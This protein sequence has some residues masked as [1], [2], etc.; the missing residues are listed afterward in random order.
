M[1]PN[2]AGV[3]ILCYKSRSFPIHTYLFAILLNPKQKFFGIQSEKAA[4]A[5]TV[6]VA[7]CKKRE[8][9]TTAQS[10]TK[11]NIHTQKRQRNSSNRNILF[12]IE[13]KRAQT[14]QHF[15]LSEMQ[16]KRQATNITESAWLVRL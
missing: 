4:T 1:A 10:E 6:V 3:R 16:Q 11:C 9:T 7:Q 5:V 12:H 13:R 2:V 15:E 14:G 8:L